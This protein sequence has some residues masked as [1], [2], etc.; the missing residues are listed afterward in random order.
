MKNMFKALVFCIALFIIVG[1]GDNGNGE[2]VGTVVQIATTAFLGV[3]PTTEVEVVKGGLTNGSG[4][5][6]GSMWATLEGRD[7]LRAKLQD[8][9][10]KNLEV[11]VK[12]HHEVISWCR[13]SSGDRFIT[14]VEFIHPA[15][16]ERP[17]NVDVK[18]LPPGC[19]KVS[20]RDKDLRDLGAM[21]MKLQQNQ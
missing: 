17:M 2:K 19:D 1:C 14:D 5:N 11:K 21:V 8:A 15:A 18:A 6:G 16:I 12:F 4:S 9:M 3:C 10:D 20:A 13:S 7:D